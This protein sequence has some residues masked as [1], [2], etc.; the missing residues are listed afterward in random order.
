[1]L[2]T[3]PLHS[4]QCTIDATS[5]APTAVQNVSVESFQTLGHAE[6]MLSVSWDPPLNVNG[7]LKSYN[8]CLSLTPLENDPQ[9]VAECEHGITVAVS[10][11]ELLAGVTDDAEYLG[12]GEAILHYIGKF[13]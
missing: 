1:M 11:G 13:M 12:E 5:P 2:F 4:Y 3:P 7:V 10:F 9:E 6:I 8:V